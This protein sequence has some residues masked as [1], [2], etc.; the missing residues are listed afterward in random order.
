[1]AGGKQRKKYP[2]ATCKYW[3]ATSSREQNP[4]LDRLHKFISEER[5]KSSRQYSLLLEKNLGKSEN[6]MPALEKRKTHLDVDLSILVDQSP[7]VFKIVCSSR[8]HY[9]QYKYSHF[10]G[11][12]KIGEVTGLFAVEDEVRI[13]PTNV[14]FADVLVLGNCTFNVVVWR[15]SCD[16]G[17]PIKCF[18][19]YY[20]RELALPLLKVN[21]SGKNK[22]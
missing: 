20:C 15:G 19:C 16:E 21:Q 7:T 2:E 13:P 17:K 4:T 9:L 11:R 3:A 22:M 14:P 12:I 18:A 6:F 8:S 1:M 10:H 5:T